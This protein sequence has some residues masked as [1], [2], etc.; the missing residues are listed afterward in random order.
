[1][2]EM[3]AI[4]ESEGFETR[5]FRYEGN[6]VMEPHVHERRPTHLDHRRRAQSR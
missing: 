5:R 3:L 4:T 6:H 1:M 2:T